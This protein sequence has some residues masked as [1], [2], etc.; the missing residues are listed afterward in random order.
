MA[1]DNMHG[2][3]VTRY[4]VEWWDMTGT[5]EVRTIS[6]DS[7]GLT[8][9]ETADG[10]FRIYYD[11][12]VTDYIYFNATADRIRTELEALEGIREVQVKDNSGSGFFNWTVTFTHDFPTVNNIPMYVGAAGLNNSVVRIT[13]DTAGVLPHAY[14]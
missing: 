6:I 10:T 9:T 1:P 8:D 13:T 5:K 4:K 2:S 12:D 7:Q 14:D 11:T 3:E